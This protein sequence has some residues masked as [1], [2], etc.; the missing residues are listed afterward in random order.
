MADAAAHGGGGASDAYATPFLADY[1]RL[2]RP[3]TSNT[4]RTRTV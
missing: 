3:E 1:H 4:I 2:V